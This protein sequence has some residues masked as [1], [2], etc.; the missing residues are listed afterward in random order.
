MNLFDLP[1]NPGRIEQRNGRIDRKLQP[2]AE[3]HFSPRPRHQSASI[4]S[5]PGRLRYTGP[6]GEVPS[7]AGPG[8]HMDCRIMEARAARW[9]A[10]AVAVS[11]TLAGCASGRSPDLDPRLAAATAA[12]GGRFQYMYIPSEGRL[13]DEAILAMWRTAGPGKM[14]RDLAS[15]MADAETLP[16]RIL[17][18]GP[19]GAKSLQVVLDA[20]SFYEGRQI[21]HLELLY[22][23]EL[24]HEAQLA[25]ALSKVGAVLRFE[26]YRE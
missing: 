4:E 15:M 22:L 23:G 26:L 14:A 17:V 21:P 13:A 20:L 7:A 10:L 16:V 18:T 2:A 19:A 12:F 1:W 8:S 3:V 5:F 11:I 24:S 9:A 25:R 6:C